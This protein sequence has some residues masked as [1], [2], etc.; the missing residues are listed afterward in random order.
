M[1]L[2]RRDLL[3]VQPEPLVLLVHRALL[4]SLVIKDLLVHRE[5]LVILVVQLVYRDQLVLQVLVPLV[6]QVFL[7]LLV[8]LLVLLVLRDY[9]DSLVTMVL[10]APL[11]LMELLDPKVPLAQLD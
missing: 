1:L 4:E 5:P 11:V 7:V 10:T 9:R 2:V 6:L 3:V 8:E